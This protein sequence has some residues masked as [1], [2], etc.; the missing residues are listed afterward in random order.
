[1]KNFE[2]FEKE[3]LEIV[4]D[5]ST[6]AVVN[7]KPA[8]CS[9]LTCDECAFSR[10]CCTRERYEWLYREYVEAPKLTK[11]ERRFCELFEGKEVWLA[12]DNFSPNSTPIV[13]KNKPTRVTFSWQGNTVSTTD[14]RRFL[15][16][17]FSFIK[18]EDEPWHISDLLKLEVE[19]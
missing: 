12:K 17:P 4:R 16:A 13:Y 9:T 2:K 6:I 11:Q 19:E 10:G 1:M 7:N 5:R 14:L 8:R 18:W 3:I 15:D